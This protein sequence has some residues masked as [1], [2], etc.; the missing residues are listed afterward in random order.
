LSW[1]AEVGHSAINKLLLSQMFRSTLSISKLKGDKIYKKYS[2][3]DTRVSGRCF[4]NGRYSI[5]YDVPV[6]VSS[7]LCDIFS[8]CFDDLER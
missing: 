6:S 5:L 1:A 7:L 8:Q 4:G 3:Q 2:K